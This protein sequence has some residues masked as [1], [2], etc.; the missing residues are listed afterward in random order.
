MI[1]RPYLIKA[2]SGGQITVMASGQ[3]SALSVGAELLGVR[4]DQ[5]RIHQVTDW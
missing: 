3:A 5:L 4:V 1:L 2:L